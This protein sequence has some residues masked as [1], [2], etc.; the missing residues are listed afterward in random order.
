MVHASGDEWFMRRATNGSYV[1]RRMA[2]M[3][4]DEWFVC[5]ATN[6]LMEQNIWISGKNINV[7]ILEVFVVGKQYQ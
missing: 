6:G 3:S 4:G 2:R 7:G 5:R 1:G